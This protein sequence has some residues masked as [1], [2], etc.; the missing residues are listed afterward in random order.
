MFL[1]FCGNFG[2]KNYFI[3]LKDKLRHVL[4]FFLILN[5]LKFELADAVCHCEANIQYNYNNIS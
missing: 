5:F 3:F 2:V 4:L 1:V